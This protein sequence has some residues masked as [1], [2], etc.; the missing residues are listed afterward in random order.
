MTGTSTLRVGTWVGFGAFLILGLLPSVVYGG[1]IGLMFTRFV[2]GF[3]D[4]SSMAARAVII[5]SAGLSACRARDL[6]T[7]KMRC[8]SRR[9][10]GAHLIGQVC[11]PTSLDTVSLAARSSR[12][13]DGRHG[14]RGPT[15][16]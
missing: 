12:R 15:G 2:L 10:S 4:T 13:R 14:A 7:T 5:S 1:Y 11:Y 6:H 9:K 3:E 16:V 8:L